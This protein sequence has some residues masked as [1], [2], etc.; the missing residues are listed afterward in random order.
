MKKIIFTVCVLGVV[1]MSGYYYQTQIIT[2]KAREATS[3]STQTSLIDTE[4]AGAIIN[5]QPE[6]SKE[7]ISTNLGIKFKY[8]D[9]FEHKAFEQGNKIFY[10]D[11]SEEMYIAVFEKPEVQNIEDSILE[12]V[13]NIGK[14][15]ENCKVVNNGEYYANP[16]F[17]MY[18]LD[19]VNPNIIYSNEE[20]DEIKLADVEAKNDGG[21][22]NGEWKKRQIYNKRL[23][24]NCSEYAEPLGLGTSSSR[25]SYFLYNGTTDK[26]KFIFLPA[27]LDPYFHEV[28]SINYLKE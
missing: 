4:T 20:L 15:L 16:K 18:V 11:W 6:L 9:G 2:E 22:F 17:E 28:G 26:T 24:D 7:Y 21:P 23:V 19:L 25:S 13:K 27:T 5:A 14:N 1:L 8:P 3:A 10:P 12:L